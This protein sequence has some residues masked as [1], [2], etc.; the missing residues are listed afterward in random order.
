MDY[1]LQVFEKGDHSFGLKILTHVE[2]NKY[3]WVMKVCRENLFG[4]AEKSQVATDTRII[5]HLNPIIQPDYPLTKELIFA[6]DNF[7]D[8][9]INHLTAKANIGEKRFMSSMVDQMKKQQDM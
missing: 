9:C 2:D 1:V 7:R 6:T 3:D 4:T 8:Q 5:R